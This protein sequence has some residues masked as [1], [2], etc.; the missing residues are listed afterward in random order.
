MRSQAQKC[1]HPERLQASHTA[2]ATRAPKNP[3]PG[4]GIRQ[5]RSRERTATPGPEPPFQ[6]LPSLMSRVPVRY[7]CVIFGSWRGNE[8]TGRDPGE[9]AARPPALRLPSGTT[10][11]KCHGRLSPPPALLTGLGGGG[12]RW[13]HGTA[14]VSLCRPDKGWP[15]RGRFLEHLAGC[16]PTPLPSLNSL[17][18][19]PP[20]LQNNN[21]KTSGG[22]RNCVLGTDN[23]THW[24]HFTAAN[25]HSGP[26][27]WLL[28][29]GCAGA[30][31]TKGRLCGWVSA[32]LPSALGVAPG[33]LPGGR[34]GCGCCG[35]HTAT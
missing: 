6:V 25:P 30:T 13:R 24:H 27:P 26:Q 20:S 5:A 35:P 15:V 16:A 1:W 11:E 18:T 32:P 8:R 34:E 2:Q 23:R 29:R 14:R 10:E 3:A 12:W 9:R 21:N 4:L 7:Q 17:P 33:C 19:S 28:P 22:T 31:V